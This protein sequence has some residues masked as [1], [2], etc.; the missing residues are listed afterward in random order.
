MDGT[1]MAAPLAA[2]VA[3][4]IWSRNPGWSAQQVKQTLLENADEIDSLGCNSTYA[5]KLGTGRINAYRALYDEAYFPPVAEFTATPLS[6]NA[7]LTVNFSDLSTG[8]I[9]QRSWDFGDGGGSTDQNPSHTYIIGGTYT[10]SLT[11]SGP[12]GNDT[13]TKTDF[14]NVTES[15]PEVGVQELGTGKYVTSGKGRNKTTLFS[16]ITIFDAGDEVIIR[17]TV[18]DASTGPV[19]NATVEIEISGPETIYLT[20]EPSNSDGVAEAKWKTSPP[21]KKKSG[22]ATGLYTA[23]VTTVAADGYIWDE[24]LSSTGFMIQESAT[25]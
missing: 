24:E 17:A 22:T 18:M 4:L 14:T 5:G 11:V 7:P 23:T 20:S 2:G 6:G 16:P 10:V 1:S 21:R 3:A 12:N 19:A 25:D 15:Q 8:T 13:E 9:S